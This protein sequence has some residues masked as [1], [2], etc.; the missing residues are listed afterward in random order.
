MCAHSYSNCLSLYSFYYSRNVT[1]GLSPQVFESDIIEIEKVMIISTC[2]NYFT[3]W[4]LQQNYALNV[5]RLRALTKQGYLL[6]GVFWN[7]GASI[8]SIKVH[9]YLN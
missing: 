2:K 7:D 3:Y 9:K 4:N 5:A 8:A 1:D 6:K